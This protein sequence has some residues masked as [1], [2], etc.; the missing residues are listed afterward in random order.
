MVDDQIDGVQRV[1]LFRVSPQVGHG[2]AHGGQIDH[3]GNAGKVLHQHA[4][5]AE[6][7]LVL[8]L[9]LVVDPGRDGPQI[10]FTD[11]VAVLVA[12]EIFQQH[13][14]GHGQSRDIGQTRRFGGRQAVVGIGLVANNEVAASL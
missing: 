13:L 14:H 2:V 12:Q 5:G 9:A 11:A 6:R 4:G 10:G 8:G 7:D 1:N 3:G